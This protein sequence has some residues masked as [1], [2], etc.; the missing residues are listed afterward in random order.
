MITHGFLAN[1]SRLY[2]TIR[3]GFFG[4]LGMADLSVLHVAQ[5]LL[6]LDLPNL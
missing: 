6:S 5:A 3:P 4:A 1:G 2:L